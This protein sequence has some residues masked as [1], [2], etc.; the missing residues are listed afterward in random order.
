MMGQGTGTVCHRYRRLED[1]TPSNG[2]DPRFTVPPHLNPKKRS[3]K[4]RQIALAFSLLLLGSILFSTYA[5]YAT[6]QITFPA[7]EER[8]TS[9]AVLVI[10]CMTFLPGA[11]VSAIIIGAWAGVPGVDYTMVP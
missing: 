7:N 2:D 10:G 11:Y 6:N 8:G 3:P 4:K 1:K 9:L 5:L